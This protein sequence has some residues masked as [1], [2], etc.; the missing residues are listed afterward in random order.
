MS[1]G[2]VPVVNTSELAR[3]M[4]NA[5]YIRINAF[6]VFNSVSHSN[7]LVYEIKHI[8]FHRTTNRAYCCSAARHIKSDSDALTI[9]RSVSPNRNKNKNKDLAIANYF[10]GSVRTY[11][12]KNQIGRNKIKNKNRIRFFLFIYLSLPLY[13]GHHTLISRMVER[14]DLSLPLTRFLFV[15]CVCTKTEPKTRNV[16][17]Q[18]FAIIYTLKLN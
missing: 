11:S 6:N 8:H 17:I 12:I 18:P 14:L 2:P 1:S 13:C 5:I 15:S 4:M 16:W 7:W 9:N 3:A 10:H